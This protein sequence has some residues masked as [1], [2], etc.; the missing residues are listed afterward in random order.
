MAAIARKPT[1]G[2]KIAECCIAEPVDKE[3]GKLQYAA[4]KLTG[5]FASFQGSTG[6]LRTLH[7]SAREP[8]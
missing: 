1:T 3:Y 5:I 4:L 7:F 8:G 6:Y 2:R